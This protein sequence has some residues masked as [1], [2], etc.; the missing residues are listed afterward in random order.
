ME[1]IEKYFIIFAALLVVAGLALIVLYAKRDLILHKRKAIT[2]EN[3]QEYKKYFTFQPDNVLLI[4]GA[5]YLAVLIVMCFL[6]LRNEVLK[7]YLVAF[8]SMAVLVGTSLGLYYTSKRYNKDLSAFDGIYENISNSYI[9]KQK[10]LEFIKVLKARRDDIR[11]DVK[12]I[13]DNCS[14]LIEGY[15]NLPDLDEVDRPLSD[16]I[17]A[18]ESIANSFDN[19]MTGIFTKSL[20]DYIKNGSISSHTYNIFNPITG[21]ELEKICTE[22]NESKKSIFSAYLV[23][24]FE[25][26]KF[27][28]NKALVKLAEVLQNHGMF[29]DEMYTKIILEYIATHEMDRGEVVEYLYKNNLITYSV[30]LECEEKGYNFIFD[31]SV[32][33]YLTEKE[34]IEFISII[35]KKD[36]YTLANKY[37]VFCTKSDCESIKKALEIAAVNNKTAELLEGYYHLLQL[38]SGYNDIST[39]YESIALTLRG[40]FVGNK[41]ELDRVSRIIDQETYLDNQVSLDA[42]YNRAL[43]DIQPV[44]DKCFN[45]LLY[46]FV[47]G[48]GCVTQVVEDKVKWLFVEYKKRLNVRGL[49]CLAA[50]LD[51]LMLVNIKE[52]DK[53][54]TVCESILASGSLCADFEYYPISANSKKNYVLYGKEII[55]NLYS[56]DNLP[57]L[58]NVIMHIESKRLTLDAFKSL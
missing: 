48:K 36:N 54:K 18:Q 4:L 3:Y 29:K 13:N 2:Y 6:I 42:M 58:K 40:Y 49:L 39:R 23:T 47:Y 17:A 12:R 38:D 14:A 53:A 30:I 31:R 28:N 32:S 27:K 33:R 7:I 5:V 52:K 56:S 25:G 22:I 8:G 41:A 26:A 21:I 10:L 20:I 55:E 57:I 34:L 9:N 11:N 15:S 50:L 24:A 44:L 43:S 46:Y 51:G 1:F 16:I 45:S 37:L 35:I 19:T